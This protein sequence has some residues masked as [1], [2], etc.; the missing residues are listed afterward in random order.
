M[1]R[2]AKYMSLA[3]LVGVLLITAGLVYV[4]DQL[5]SLKITTGYG[6]YK[7]VNVDLWNTASVRILGPIDVNVAE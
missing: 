7:R 3:I 1:S 5:H 4:G 2:D 6:E